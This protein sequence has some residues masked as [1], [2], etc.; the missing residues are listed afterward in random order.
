VQSILFTGLLTVASVVL[1][2]LWELSGDLTAATH[3]SAFA[4]VGQGLAFLGYLAIIG[5]WLGAMIAA[6]SGHHV[7]L[8][9]IGAYAERY[10]APPREPFPPAFG[11]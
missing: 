5:L 8:P 7:R 11:D 10:A 9:I 2:I 6:W 3:Q 4:H 1:Y